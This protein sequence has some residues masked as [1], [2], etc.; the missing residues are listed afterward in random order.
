MALTDRWGRAL[1][2]VWVKTEDGLFFMDGAGDAVF[3]DNSHRSGASSQGTFN[4]DVHA[5]A[6][7]RAAMTQ[8]FAERA[9]ASAVER[10]G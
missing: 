2:W 8:V 5:S 1:A 7:Y 4:D 3:H 6:E 9:I 10:A